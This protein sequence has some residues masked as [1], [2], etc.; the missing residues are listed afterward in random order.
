MYVLCMYCV[1]I[2][3]VLCMYYVCIMYVLCMYYVCFI[4]CVS[5]TEKAFD[6]SHVS[7]KISLFLY[8][9]FLY[10]SFFTHR[11]LLTFFC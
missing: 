9:L 6:L 10:S 7:K 2:M 11:F 4:N 3:Y 1:C 5:H 8:S